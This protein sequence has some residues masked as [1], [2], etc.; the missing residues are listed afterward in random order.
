MTC[1]HGFFAALCSLC[2]AVR[3]QPRLPPLGIKGH[4]P[5]IPHVT[6]TADTMQTKLTLRL[7]DRLI[8][9]AKAYAQRSGKSL[10][11][12]VADLL[13][14]LQSPLT[15]LPDTAP[16]TRSPSVRALAGALAGHEVDLEDYQRHRTQKHR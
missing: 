2:A 14:R 11:E 13:A 7:D 8:R 9:R 12:L 3:Q 6:Y 1:V 5:Y 10:S 16:A 4:L 15:D